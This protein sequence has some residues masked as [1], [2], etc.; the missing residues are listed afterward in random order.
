MPR[1]A[2]WTS[3]RVRFPPS[4][5]DTADDVQRLPHRQREV[6]VLDVWA[7]LSRPQTAATLRVGERTVAAAQASRWRRSA[8]RTSRRTAEAT[9]DRVAEALERQADA[10][11]ADDLGVGSERSS[12]RTPGGQ[13]AIVARGW[14]RS[15]CSSSWLS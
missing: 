5:R 4:V 7:R 10:V 1:S 3:G 9:V 13:R 15:L 14:S 12:T 2:P 8:D 11:G 6:V